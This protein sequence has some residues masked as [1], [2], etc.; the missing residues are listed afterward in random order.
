MKDI[1]K[2]FLKEQQE[3]YDTYE[4]LRNY[5]GPDIILRD[6][7]KKLIDTG[8]ITNLELQKAISLFKKEFYG[9]SIYDSLKHN[10]NIHSLIKDLGTKTYN[11]LIRTD[12][13]IMLD[14]NIT[15]KVGQPERNWILQNVRDLVFFR[16]NII[17]TGKNFFFPEREHKMT[18]TEECNKLI[19]QLGARDFWGFVEKDD[20]SILNRIN[21]NYTNWIKLISKSHL[22]GELRGN[23][24]AEKVSSYF[25]DRPIEDVVD[26]S[27]YDSQQ[28]EMIKSKVPKMSLADVDVISL[29]ISADNSESDYD[30][31][32]MVERIKKTTVKGEEAEK[33]FVND[34]MSYGIPSEDIKIF[35]SYGNLVDITFQCDLMFKLDNNWVPIQVKS[36]ESKYSKLLSYDIGGLLVY[37]AP[38]KYNCGNWIYTDGKS[39]PKAFNEI[40]NVA[41]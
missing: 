35:S 11:N 36:F 9:P 24:L 10:Q 12:K 32:R 17:D 6:I 18:I 30:Y 13:K 39:L 28:Q 31:K 33:Q 4:M 41:C 14:K 27:D 1:I 37:P 8:K 29:L 2:N 23:T 22:R 7:S 15:I 26:M 38:P 40:I 5:E 3:K 16:N 21:T 25:E 34:L 20:W 19:R